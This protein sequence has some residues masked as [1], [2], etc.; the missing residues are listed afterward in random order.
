MGEH[1]EA[2]YAGFPASNAA[3]KEL[4]YGCRRSFPSHPAGKAFHTFLVTVQI[5]SY[6][7]NKFEGSEGGR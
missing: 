4:R 7:V 1:A 5:K 6:A 3:K 2:D